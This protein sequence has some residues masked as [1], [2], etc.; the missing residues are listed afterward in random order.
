M[1]R[2]L[3]R[4]LEPGRKYYVQARA[5]NGDQTSQWSQLWEVETTSDLMPPA[6]PTGLTWVVEGTAFKAVWTGP[7]TNQDGTPL[8]DF[9]DF[10]VKIWS[11]ANPA[12]VITYYTTSARFDLP[13]ELNVNAFGT[14]RP[15]VNFEVRARDNTGNISAAATATATNPPPANVAGLSV[16]GISD[17]I[18][19]RWNANADEDL[20]HYEVYQGTALGVT[21]NLVYTGPGT[22]FV[23][24]TISASPV[25][26]AVR[27][28]DVF[29]TPSA[30]DATESATARSTNPS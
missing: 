2:I 25:Y 18:A 21:P 5:N 8:F 13:F 4:D 12:A 26:F 14:P 17:A 1:T 22:S 16:T 11:D 30:V 7:T 9:R 6:V 28:V 29:G 23:F 3:L 20:K 19:L 27:A 24:D 10:Q 15:Q